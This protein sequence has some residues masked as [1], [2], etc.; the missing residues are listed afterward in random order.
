MLEINPKK[1]KIMIFQKLPRK[2]LDMNLSIDNERI[3]IVQHLY[4]GSSGVPNY[5]LTT[6]VLANSQLTTIFLAN[7]QLTANFFANYQLTVNAICT[8]LKCPSNSK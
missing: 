3:E 6:N 1:T 4:E 5:H 8:L 2:S 7:Y